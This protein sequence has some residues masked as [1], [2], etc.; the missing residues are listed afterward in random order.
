MHGNL[1]ALLRLEAGAAERWTASDTAA[2]IERDIPPER[3]DA[4][5]AC[6]PTPDPGS[7]ARIIRLGAIASTGAAA[8]YHRPWPEEL[9][10]RMVALTER[11]ML[12]GKRCES[13][14]AT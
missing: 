8:R 10:G 1:M 14:D 5:S 11:D 2:S 7:L 13:P 3:L 9:A 6:V 12:N 4:L